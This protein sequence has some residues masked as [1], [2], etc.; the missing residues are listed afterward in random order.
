MWDV[1][2]WVNKNRRSNTYDVNNNLI[3]VIWEYWYY[4]YPYPFWMYSQKITYTYD[5]GNNL[6]E[7]LMQNWDFNW[8]NN[9]KSTY[10][11]DAY[12]NLIEELSQIW[13]NSYWENF[14]RYLYNYDVKNNRIVELYQDWEVSNW[15]DQ[16]KFLYSYDVNN[17]M[18]EWVYQNWIGSNWVNNSKQ[19]FTYGPITNIDEEFSSLISFDLSNNYPNPFNPSTTI[20]YQIPELSFITL[21]VFDVLGNEITTL[22]NDE[23]AAGRYEVQFKA[24]TL[25][26]GTYFYRMQVGH[27]VQTR[28]MI[29]LK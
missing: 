11:Y 8:V 3:Q 28:K 1:S 5:L 24:S 6:I 27:F 4:V 22:V 20:K 2:G 21:K 14:S 9:S 17:N 29:L 26:S 19:T 23:R 12:S 10:T 7:M 15:V 18:I 25:T 13:E 16:S